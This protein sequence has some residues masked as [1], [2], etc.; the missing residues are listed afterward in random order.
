VAPVILTL[1]LDHAAE[2]FFQEMRSKW[3]PPALNLIPAHV[4][5][6]HHLPGEDLPALLGALATEC[7]RETPMPVSVAG[8]RHLGRGVAYTLD[9]PPASAFRARLAAR[10]QADLTAQDRQGWRPHVTIQNK[11]DP[12]ESRALHAALAR[13]FVPFTAVAVGLRA[14]RYLG[15]PWQHAGTVPFAAA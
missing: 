3:F 9:A 11:V 13:D 12:A 2:Q 8:L 1:A 10:W 7:E 14:W 5:L 6:F 4:T 15:G